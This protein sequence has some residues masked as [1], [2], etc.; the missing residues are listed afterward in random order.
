MNRRAFLAA[1]PLF[2]TVKRWL[3]PKPQI[4]WKSVYRSGVLLCDWMPQPRY[5]ILRRMKQE[6]P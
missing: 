5:M 2:A 6:Q 3:K 4:R 1:L